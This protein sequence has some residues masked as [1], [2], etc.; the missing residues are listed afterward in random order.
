MLR[1][2]TYLKF[3]TLLSIFFG[4]WHFKI[5]S[6]YYCKKKKI[7]QR[8]WRQNFLTPNLKILLKKKIKT[9]F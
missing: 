2:V 1:T 6:C 4:A 7:A 5:P 3:Y 8:N 9:I